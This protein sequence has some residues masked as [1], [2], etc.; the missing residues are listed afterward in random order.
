[1]AGSSGRQT[2]S[3]RA[4]DSDRNNTCQVLDSALSDGQLSMEEHRL[5]VAAATQAAT[6]GNL[7]HLVDDLQTENAPV[8]M[9]NLSRPSRFAGGSGV[10]AGLGTRAAV[11]GVLVVLGIAIGWGL[12]GNTSSPLSFTSDPGAKSDGIPAKVITPPKQLQSLGGLNGLLEQ[13]RQ[14]FG[15]TMGYGLVIY[16]E[17]AVLSRADPTDDRRKLSYTY[18]GGFDDPSTSAKDADDVPVDLGAFDVEKTVALLRGAAETV[19]L[20]QQDVKADST[21]LSIDPANDPL[22]PGALQLRASVSSEFGSGAVTFAGD[23][24]IKRIDS[25][26]S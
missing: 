24:T 16:P 14:R 17:Y 7:Q 11:A 23:G 8:Q 5:R 18:R 12:Y 19:G 20:Q 26:V 4:K 3:T 1:M 21:Y 22:A 9:P 10:A 2:A 15:D 6:L 25:A 13:M